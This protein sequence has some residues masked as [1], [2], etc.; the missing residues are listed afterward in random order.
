MPEREKGEV[1]EKAASL[2]NT[3]RQ[4][5]DDADAIKKVNK[6]YKRVGMKLIPEETIKVV[7]EYLKA[8]KAR[9][10]GRV[11]LRSCNLGAKKQQ[12]VV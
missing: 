9:Q 12:Y 3:N 1:K 7:E 10:D 6:F 2:F 11:K 5:I 4:Y 8:A